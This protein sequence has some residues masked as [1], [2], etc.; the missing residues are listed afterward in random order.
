MTIWHMFVACWI[1]KATNAFRVCNTYCFSTAT[2]IARTRLNVK[3]HVHFLSCWF[4]LLIQTFLY[5]L[6][7]FPISPQSPESDIELIYLYKKHVC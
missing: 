5:H 3:L 1:P 7:L 2:V 6:F 4:M